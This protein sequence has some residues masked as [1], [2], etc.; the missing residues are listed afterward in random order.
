MN[1]PLLILWGAIG[2]SVTALIQAITTKNSLTNFWLL[3]RVVGV[4]GGILGGWLFTL[5]WSSQIPIDG[6][7]AAATSIGA[8]AGA[9]V[10][11]DLLSKVQLSPQP[12][13][14]N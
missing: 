8:I 12:D 6:V 14:P 9:I 13:P 4:V 5:A 7:G 11:T 2:W 3:G 10:L 1:I